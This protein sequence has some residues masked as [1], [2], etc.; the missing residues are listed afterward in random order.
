MNKIVFFWGILFTVEM[1]P[2]LGWRKEQNRQLQMKVDVVDRYLLLLD[3]KE[4]FN[5]PLPQ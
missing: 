1:V 4:W 2:A 3:Q 5:G